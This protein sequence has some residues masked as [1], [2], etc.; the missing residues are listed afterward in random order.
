VRTSP[1]SKG[2][3]RRRTGLRAALRGRTV[4]RAG[5]ATGTVLKTKDT[6]ASMCSDQRLQIRIRGCHGLEPLAVKSAS[7]VKLP[8][9]SPQVDSVSHFEF[10]EITVACRTRQSALSHHQYPQHQVSIEFPACVRTD[11]TS[12][13]RTKACGLTSSEK[14]VTQS[15]CTDDTRRT[16]VTRR[17]VQ[18]PS[19]CE[20]DETRACLACSCVEH[21]NRYCN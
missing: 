18:N 19:H 11:R 4:H 2:V 5:A 1:A 3:P 20:L 16:C 10:Y 8:S 14:H 9:V 7:L 12:T 15:N 21:H 17:K 6:I 13:D